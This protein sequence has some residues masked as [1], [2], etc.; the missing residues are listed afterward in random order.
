MQIIINFWFSYIL[1]DFLLQVN[2]RIILSAQKIC[3]LRNRSSAL[4]RKPPLRSTASP[5][6]KLVGWRK[7][8]L[9]HLRILGEENNTTSL[10]QHGIFWFIEVCFCGFKHLE[11]E[12]R[13]K[14]KGH[15]ETIGATQKLDQ[16]EGKA[17][18]KHGQAKARDT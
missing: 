15:N 11:L 7:G 12:G 6:R 4:S 3:L 17:G 9:F 8:S 14:P 2:V 5:G 13:F 16:K 10:Y 1:S 18:P